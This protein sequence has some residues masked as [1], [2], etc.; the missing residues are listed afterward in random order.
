MPTDKR[1]LQQIR[2]R[3]I[4]DGM[5][6][7]TQDEILEKVMNTRNSSNNA[8]PFRVE[9]DPHGTVTGILYKDL[10]VLSLIP[11]DPINEHNAGELVRLLNA[12]AAIE[13][14]IKEYKA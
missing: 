11:A 10:Q 2:K 8:Q 13:E 12:A 14:F 5:R 7:L 1:K 6:L 9:R 4:K 3:A